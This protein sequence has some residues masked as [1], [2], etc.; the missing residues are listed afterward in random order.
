MNAPHATDT[1]RPGVTPAQAVEKLKKHYETAVETARR[2][3][4][5]GIS[6]GDFSD[7]VNV[8]YL[9]LT[10]RVHSWHPV[11]RTQPGF[12]ISDFSVS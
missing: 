3:L 12:P 6:N 2:V 11:D 8:T 5:T 4:E 9:K 1:L 10:V 7:Y